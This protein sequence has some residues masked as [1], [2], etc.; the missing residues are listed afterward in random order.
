MEVSQLIIPAPLS[1]QICSCA[2]KAT[3]NGAGSLKEK[4]MTVSKSTNSQEECTS[5]H[6]KFVAT[7]SDEK[8]SAN[9]ESTDNED[10][11]L[12]N[13]T[14]AAN[15]DATSKE[16]NN[17]DTSPNDES[18]YSDETVSAGNSLPFKSYKVDEKPESVD[19]GNN[20]TVSS[21]ELTFKK[22]LHAGPSGIN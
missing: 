2:I 10:N 16:I 1:F 19:A 22:N 12:I 21:G 6:T 11:L 9:K 8:T 3:V 4:H 18:K 17:E 14:N 13:D 15:D 7:F 5:D 20:T